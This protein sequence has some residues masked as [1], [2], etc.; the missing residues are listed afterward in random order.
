MTFV[1]KFKGQPCTEKDLEK[2]ILDWHNSRTD[3]K[4]YDALGVS[5]EEYMAWLMRQDNF[6]EI[7]G[8]KIR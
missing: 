8:K 4:I 2:F 6:E 7:F 1:E 5:Q 3:V